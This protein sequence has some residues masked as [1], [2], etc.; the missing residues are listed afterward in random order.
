MPARVA[1][2]ASGTGSLLDV[3]CRAA[4]DG[5]L[6]CTVV[7]LLSDRPDVGALAVAARHGVPASVVQPRDHPDRAA[8][9]VALAEQL[10]EQRPDWVVSVGFMRVL[11][12]AVLDRF[13]NRVLN[14]HPALLPSFP[15]AHAVRDALAHGVHVTGATVHLVD[16]GVDT[17]PILAQEAVPVLPGDDEAVLHERI[18]VVERQL[19]LR[20]LS[21]LLT[22][23][24]R[25]TGRRAV[26]GAGPGA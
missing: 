10:A 15:G 6:D 24:V 17:G 3:L 22:A 25:L 9:D 12:P 23:G 20:T 8:W 4:G 11:G 18:K 1:A 14:T 5:A 21:A 13:P 7:G 16:A 26:L 2:L 19:L